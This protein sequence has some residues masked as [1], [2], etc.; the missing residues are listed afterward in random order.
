MLFEASCNDI[1]AL[2][3]LTYRGGSTDLIDHIIQSPVHF[4]DSPMFVS[5]PIFFSGLLVGQ[6]KRTNQ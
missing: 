4:Q 3:R 5:Y 6:M 2:L 1:I